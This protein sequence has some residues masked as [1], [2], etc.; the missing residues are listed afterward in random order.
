M[1]D[2]F[3][4]LFE[5]LHK[6]SPSL[7]ATDRP[8]ILRI[9]IDKLEENNRKIEDLENRLN[10]A[11][12]ASAQMPSNSSSAS[13]KVG[14]MS[15][16]AP[17][18][19]TQAPGEMEKE[20]VRWG[21]GLQHPPDVRQLQMEHAVGNQGEMYAASN[22]GAMHPNRRAGGE[23]PFV[24]LIDDRCHSDDEIAFAMS[25]QTFQDAAGFDGSDPGVAAGHH[26]QRDQ[27]VRVDGARAWAAGKAKQSEAVCKVLLELE[28][29]LEYILRFI[30][31]R[32]VLSM[33][34][35]CK[36]LREATRAS[37]FWVSFKLCSAPIRLALSS[38]VPA[39]QGFAEL[40]TRFACATLDRRRLGRTS[41]EASGPAP[42]TRPR[43]GLAT[44]T[45]SASGS[46]C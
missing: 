44:S 45:T 42:S 28:D 10:A 22:A 35:V 2:G 37:P 15:C 9:A 8:G 7:K 31:P 26:L 3:A 5:L 34:S 30:E 20:A 46:I 24:N 23:H 32:D 41:S 13:V 43:P 12:A 14:M 33:S 4:R 16:S 18:G 21:G 6:T 25:T 36:R 40:T 39:A 1:S 27:K 19:N 11:L 29:P 38:P 17:S